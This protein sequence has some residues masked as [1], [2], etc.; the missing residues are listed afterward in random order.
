LVLLAPHVFVEP[1]TLA[2][3]AAIREVYRTSDLKARLARHHAHVDD[4][5]LGWADAW[6]DP[7]F[8]AWSIEAGVA[9]VS[10]PMLLIQGRDDDYG[11]LAQLDR[12]QAQATAPAVRLVLDHCG[13]APQRDQ[14]AVVLAAIVAFA[15][16]L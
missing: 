5:F 2:S 6:L 7:Q 10:A 4:A 14:D 3:I 16:S 1:V 11:T 15:R 13:H 8:A 12:I 9:G